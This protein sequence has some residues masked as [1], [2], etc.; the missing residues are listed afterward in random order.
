MEQGH[1]GVFIK[2]TIPILHIWLDEL[3]CSFVGYR[4][5]KKH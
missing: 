1:E 5:N 3:F 2:G 4:L